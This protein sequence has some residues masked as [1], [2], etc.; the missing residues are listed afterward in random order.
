MNIDAAKARQ[1]ED[2]LLENLSEGGNNYEVWTPGLQL[3]HGFRLT[4]L[5][6]LHYGDA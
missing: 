3:L 4:Q 6:W 2:I 1:I 5:L